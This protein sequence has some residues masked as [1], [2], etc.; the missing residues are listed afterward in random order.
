MPR[1]AE[2]MSGLTRTAAYPIYPSTNL[3]LCT[4]PMQN[5]RKTTTSIA[6]PGSHDHLEQLPHAASTTPSVVSTH[7][8]A[9]N[10]ITRIY[11]SCLEAVAKQPF[12]HLIL[13]PQTVVAGYLPYY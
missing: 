7:L 13:Q 6:Q 11:R 3:Q 4:V 8:A 1:R 9:T 5:P 10:P 2:H 12:H